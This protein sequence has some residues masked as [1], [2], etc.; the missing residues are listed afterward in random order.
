MNLENK[1][2]LFALTFE[3][4]NAIFHNLIYVI[5]KS[6]LMLCTSHNMSLNKTLYCVIAFQDRHCSVYIV[7]PKLLQK[8]QISCFV[9]LYHSKL[10]DQFY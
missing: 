8:L 5:A 7:M 9:F 4:K 6:N 2:S 10:S 3:H 1:L